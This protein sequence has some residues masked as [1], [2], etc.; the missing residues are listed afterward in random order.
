MK[1]IKQHWDKIALAFILLL[2][3]FLSIYNIGN[4]GYSNEFYAASVKSMIQSWKNFFCVSLDPGGWVTVDKP[5]VSLWVQAAFAKVFGF[6]G[7]SILLP[8]SLAAIAGVLIIFH[9]VKRHFGRV[10]GLI[11]A[12]ALALSPIYIVV[13]KTNNTDSVLILFMVLATW[14]MM[15]AAD[16]GKL[17]YLILSAVLLGVAYNAKTLEAFLILPALFVVYLFGTN[18]KWRTRAW[19]LAVATVV[20]AAVSL[21]WSAAVDL[22]PASERPYVDNSTTNSE[23]ELAIGY[24]GIQRITGQNSGGASGSRE[25]S[26]KIPSSETGTTGKS[27]GGMQPRGGGTDGNQNNMPSGIPEGSQN[28]YGGPNGNES[29]GYAPTGAITESGS[30][31]GSVSA[32]DSTTVGNPFNIGGIGGIMNG[33]GNSFN[34]GG[35]ASPLRMF[36]TTLG[37]QD[38]WLLPFG[39]FTMLALLL[40]CIRAHD[41][42]TRRK[43]L[44][45]LLMWGV[46]VLTMVAYFSVAGFF[47]PYYI[48][49]LAPFLAALI[50]IG[51]VEMWKL[52]KEERVLGFLLPLALIATLVVQLG[53]LRSYPSFASVMIPLISIV[54]GVPSIALAVLKPLGKC[55]G[56]TASACVGVALAG[57]LIT[58]AVWLGYSVFT[59]S[60]NAQIPSA[61]PSAT[62]TALSGGNRSFNMGE[63]QN[64]QFENN[65]GQSKNDSPLK[66]NAPSGSSGGNSA[67]NATRSGSSGLESSSSKLISFLEKNNTGEK[68][69]IA[70]PDASEAEPIIL[71][72]GKPVIAI[73]GFS[74]NDN[75]MTV[76]KLEELV[77]SGQLKYFM[78]GGGKSSG[79]TSSEVTAWVEKYGK[80]VDSSKWSDSSSGSSGTGS[81]SSG[82]LYDLSSYK[83]SSSSTSSS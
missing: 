24:N 29:G 81:S 79:S 11:S 15:V 52:Y 76:A 59:N 80:A 71:A 35:S 25:M 69:L 34:G 51:T 1:V 8:E 82:T 16:K 56:K 42:E 43:L 28:E 78:V 20:L 9:I 27:E 57:L 5:P 23:L 55:S 41:R 2:A 14:A 50:G 18:L 22:T 17:R 63:Q 62:E 33:G 54:T 26:G 83:T 68:W 67:G 21:S 77:K 72:T 31:G 60:F 48:S 10:A 45:N 3:G 64:S 6:H 44:R 40:R 61:G 38:S 53:M 36:N 39:L 30:T 70:V 37:G 7:W 73:G 32:S 58:P 75:T 12:L 65:G 19:H 4:Q 13:S 49:A 46:S 74:G 66:S 47:H